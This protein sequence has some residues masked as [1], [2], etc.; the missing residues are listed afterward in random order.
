MGHARPNPRSTEAPSGAHT[1]EQAMCPHFAHIPTL[2][3]FAV[4]HMRWAVGMAVPKVIPGAPQ[5]EKL[6][7]PSSPGGQPSHLKG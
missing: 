2:S 1:A 6:R 4:D 7:I 5:P 3:L